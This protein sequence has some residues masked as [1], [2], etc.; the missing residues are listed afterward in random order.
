MRHEVSKAQAGRGGRSKPDGEVVG[1]VGSSQLVCNSGISSQPVSAFDWHSCK[2][3]CLWRLR[4]TRQS[5]WAWPAASTRC[6]G[7]CA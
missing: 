4:M 1:V 6:G 3:A 2:A 5:E 7:R